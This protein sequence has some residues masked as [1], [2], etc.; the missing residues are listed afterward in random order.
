MPEGLLGGCACGQVRYR[1]AASP[2]I[3]HCC[4]CTECQRQTGS[5]FVLNA[6]IETARLQQLGGDTR[7]VTLPTESGLPHRVARCTGCGTALWSHYGGRSLDCFVRVGTLDAPA[8]LPPD[9]H[10]FTRSKLPWVV[11][12]DGVPAFP[13]YYE[14]DQVWPA[15]SLARRRALFG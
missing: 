5:A 12:P 10:I 15:A 4:H 9:V 7:L 2:L 13:D 8:R 1:L 3:V 14:L 6:L 11:L